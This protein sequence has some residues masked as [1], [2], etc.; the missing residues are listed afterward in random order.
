MAGCGK[1]RPTE[2]QFFPVSFLLNVALDCPAGE[3]HFPIDDRR[4]FWTRCSC[5]MYISLHLIFRCVL[6]HS[7]LIINRTSDYAHS[8]TFLP[9]SPDFGVGCGVLSLSI[10]C[11]LCWILY[12]ND[13]SSPVIY[14]YWRNGL[15]YNWFPLSGTYDSTWYILFKI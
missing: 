15:H 1:N 10:H 12:I 8:I 5:W 11:L 9:R 3:Q 4:K 6:K 7:E 13:F 2:P 14:I